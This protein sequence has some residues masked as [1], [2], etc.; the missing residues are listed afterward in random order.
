MRDVGRVFRPAP[1][2]G[3]K[4]RSTYGVRGGLG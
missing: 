1:E 3:L 2:P 4:T